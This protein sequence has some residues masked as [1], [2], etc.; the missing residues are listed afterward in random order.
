M[1]LGHCF[2]PRTRLGQPWGAATTTIPAQEKPLG[3]FSKGLGEVQKDGCDTQ[4]SSE[5][6][7]LCLLIPAQLYH[8][9]VKVD[10]V[11][12]PG[13][14]AL[15]IPWEAEHR[16]HRPLMVREGLGSQSCSVRTPVKLA[17]PEGSFQLLFLG[18]F[19]PAMQK[20]QQ[21][22]SGLQMSGDAPA[23]AEMKSK[24]ELVC[25]SMYF[26][27]GSAVAQVVCSAKSS[28]VMELGQNN[29]LQNSWCP[30]YPNSA[31]LH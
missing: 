22:C 27:F 17:S 8:R 20:P 25:A 16:T 12:L 4:I 15:L 31:N 3:G 6:S 14:K 19:C 29:R 28:L 24:E 11:W 7:R 5:L 23:W 2:H 9:Q 26:F 13:F 1:P 30:V 21:P 10:Y 18:N